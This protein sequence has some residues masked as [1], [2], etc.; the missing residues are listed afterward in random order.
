MPH[1]PLRRFVSAQAFV[2]PGGD[3][4]EPKAGPT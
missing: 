1:D 2:L 4:P 3:S